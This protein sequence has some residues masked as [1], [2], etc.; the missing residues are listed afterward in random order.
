MATIDKPPV[1]S[2][3]GRSP[4]DLTLE[5]RTAYARS[6]IALEVYSPKTTP[7]RRI[8]AIG[9]SVEECIALLRRRGLEPARFEFSR[10]KPP[11]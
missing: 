11:Y 9:D 10:L 5:E 1:E 6:W 8:E 3:L 7:L 2:L 4:E